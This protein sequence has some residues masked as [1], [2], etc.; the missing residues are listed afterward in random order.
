MNNDDGNILFK[1][2]LLLSK[3]K[4]GTV[5]G[6]CVNTFLPLLFFL[7]HTGL[8]KKNF[9]LSCCKMWNNLTFFLSLRAIIFPLGFAFH[10]RRKL[11]KFEMMAVWK[12]SFPLIN[13]WHRH[14]GDW[15]DFSLNSI[16]ISPLEIA[17][18]NV[19]NRMK[20]GSGHPIIFTH[21][22]WLEI[23]HHL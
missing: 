20:R 8:L 17:L 6:L 23:V 12:E 11:G 19:I 9:I 15:H 14:P 4:G 1:V 13:I 16:S 2:A 7:C 10:G 22:L 21:F 18:E 5:Y 3:K